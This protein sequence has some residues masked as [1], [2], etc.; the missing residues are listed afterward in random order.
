MLST[1]DASAAEPFT[2]VQDETPSQNPAGVSEAD[3]TEPLGVL[4]DD[5]FSEPTT[6]ERPLPE[7]LEK[8][9]PLPPRGL[10]LSKPFGG[11]TDGEDGLLLVPREYR[12]AELSLPARS[13]SSHDDATRVRYRPEEK[14]VEFI[15]AVLGQ[16]KGT[17]YEA[18]PP[19]TPGLAEGPAEEVQL[20]GRYPKPR[21]RKTRKEELDMAETSGERLE[22]T[23]GPNEEK[24]AELRDDR[25]GVASAEN[26]KPGEWKRE[27]KG[28]SSG[29]KEEGSSGQRSH[30]RLR[31]VVATDLVL[32]QR[33]AAR[34]T[35]RH[36]LSA[37][38]SD[39]GIGSET[40]SAQPSAPFSAGTN[41]A[42]A[43]GES[44][45]NRSQPESLSGGL[46]FDEGGQNTGPLRGGGVERKRS[47]LSPLLLQ[48][49]VSGCRKDGPGTRT[50]LWEEPERAAVGPVSAVAVAE[51]LASDVSEVFRAAFGDDNFCGPLTVDELCQEKHSGG[52]IKPQ[53][54]MQIGSP[55]I[56]HPVTPPQ[57]WAVTLKPPG[58]V[59][60]AGTAAP[61]LENPDVTDAGTLVS[62]VGTYKLLSSP[63]FLVGYQEDWL[64]IPQGVLKQWEKAP[65]EPYAA[66]KPVVYYA[67]CPADGDLVPLCG[68]YLKEVGSTYEMCQLG[69]HVAASLPSD[70][71]TGSAPGVVSVALG[72]DPTVE[73]E[74]SV[75][76]A[77][78]R[79][80]AFVEG[81]RTAAT[82][83]WLVGGNGREGREGSEDPCTVSRAFH[84]L[85]TCEMYQ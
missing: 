52:A 65:L 56:E 60:S 1:N 46:R 38:S 79:V 24:Q 28:Q 15:R 51:V 78:E 48:Q 17:A 31:S 35:G 77:G 43:G 58:G 54:A 34:L 3:P 45:P 29:G 80:E 7:N 76:G 41:S 64:R 70:L 13:D 69:S 72:S 49:A 40:D 18:L 53:L 22:V 33:E 36:G 6:D 83:L 57:L 12:T 8:G 50:G 59:G 73:Y 25:K 16:E 10:A 74:A 71:A 82:R 75:K 67:F 14:T 19:G 4:L 42:W 20:R 9:S 27:G 5:L 81:I 63:P 30:A 85:L 66:P 55:A 39:D 47:R 23:G 61:P 44:E 2:A 26:G 21:G 37:A 84:L 11:V 68:R 32:L 62:D